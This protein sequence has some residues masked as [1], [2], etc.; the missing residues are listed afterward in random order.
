MPDG[1]SWEDAKRRFGGGEVAPA[2]KAAPL[3]WEDA[4]AKFGGGMAVAE[5]PPDFET[6]LKHAPEAPVDPD[7]PMRLSRPLDQQLGD[8]PVASRPATAAAWAEQ[9][10]VARSPLAGDPE[11]DQRSGDV[12][13]EPEG[14]VV[15]RLDREDAERQRAAAGDRADV[16]AWNSYARKKFGV[17]A[18]AFVT[19]DP[20][21]AR[22]RAA[23]NAADEDQEYQRDKWRIMV[24]EV[25]RGVARGASM[26][27]ADPLFNDQTAGNIKDYE[28]KA[29]RR[30]S[31]A[32]FVEQAAYAGTE[33]AASLPTFGGLGRVATAAHVPKALHMPAVMGTYG[34]VS[35]ESGHRLEG[36][37]K[38]I[39]FG[40]L[41]P[42]VS[43]RLLQALSKLTPEAAEAVMARVNN[44]ISQAGGFTAAGQ[45]I[46]PGEANAGIDAL[47]GAG[48]GLAGARTVFSP[49]LRDVASPET[50]ANRRATAEAALRLGRDPIADVNADKLGRTDP[51]VE[52]TRVQAPPVVTRREEDEAPARPQEAPVPTEAP[53]VPEADPARPGG[54]VEPTEAPR[55]EAAPAL[56]AQKPETRSADRIESEGK[57]KSLVEYVR[58]MGGIRADGYL[59]GEVERL[60]VK[61]SATSGLVARAKGRGLG[62]EEM[63]QSL[64][65]SGYPVEDMTPPQLLDAIE[66]EATKR[67]APTLSPETSDLH[68]LAEAD[69]RRRAESD[70]RQLQDQ[71]AP[72]PEAHYAEPGPTSMKRAVVDAE[73]AERG[74]EPVKGSEPQTREGWMEYGRKAV[75]AD[76]R[77]PDILIEKFE[78]DPSL[79]MKPHERAIL[80]V[81]QVDIRRSRALADAEGVDAAK[82]GDLGAL[83]DATARARVESDAL[84]RLD[85][86]SKRSGE[87]WS[88]SGSAAQMEVK[89]DYSL[90][91]NEMKVRR[92][93]AYRE[94]SERESA[95]VRAL[96]DRASKAEA[97]R[98][99]Y[100]GR[101]AEV[102]TWR[103]EHSSRKAPPRASPEYG[104]KNKIVTREAYEESG[105]AIKEILGRMGSGLDKLAIVP[106]LTKRAIFH[107]EA[108]G[109]GFASWA[110]QMRADFGDKVEPYLKDAWDAAQADFAP[111]RIAALEKS[112]ERSIAEYNRRIASGD[113]FPA[114]K[115]D[116]PS[117]PKLDA[118]RA[119]RDEL[120]KD[121]ASLREAARPRSGASAIAEK[122]RETRLQKTLDELE[123]RVR[124]NDVSTKPAKAKLPPTKKAIEL[125][126]KVDL[127]HR[128]VDEMVFRHHLAN[129]S[130]A[131]KAADTVLQ[132]AQTARAVMTSFDVSAPLRQGLFYAGAHP[133]AAARALGP[134]LQAMRSPEGMARIE[135]EMRMDADFHAAKRSGV[136]FSESG[137]AS[138]I[139]KMEEAYMSR[140]AEKIPLVAGSQRAYTTFL[141]RA[142][143]DYFKTL[144]AGFKSGREA[145]PKE[146]KA[147]ASFVNA[148]TGRGGPIGEAPWIAG[149]NHYLFSP[150]LL[151][152]RIQLLTGHG[153]IYGGGSLRT[154]MIIAKEYARFLGSTAA[155]FGMAFAAGATVEE[156][157][158]S[159]DF[160]KLRWGNARL[161]PL[162]G[163]AQVV[164]LVSRVATGESKPTG[165]GVKFDWS[166]ARF[167]RERG[168]GVYPI[169]GA[170]AKPG[171]MT[172]VLTRFLR[173]KL[174]P[175]PGAIWSSAAGEDV[176]G[177]KTTAARE[178]SGL[179]I[180]MSFGGKDLFSTADKKTVTPTFVTG[181]DVFQAMKQ[182]GVPAGAAMWVLSLFGMGLQ[183]H[184]EKKKNKPNPK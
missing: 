27:L 75:E 8:V 57:G 128:A 61:G 31:E 9:L 25:A 43:H 147:I 142:R 29:N 39:A 28:A 95:E 126:A 125:Q 163:M 118:L 90:A 148:A 76:S 182:Q 6:F 158:R 84:A 153:V 35:A 46:N 50:L 80:L 146:M 5:A 160:G 20:A 177:N 40:F 86:I 2:E 38:G 113:A 145:T 155:L 59:A 64:K 102:E 73:R 18:Q 181:S 127:A 117:G 143:L 110:A 11:R 168:A 37:G 71:P 45:L 26:G 144:T 92:E 74:L 161:D 77:A 96:S 156:D 103:A 172:Q 49:R 136:F 170:G 183:V 174:A 100:A 79:S 32:G 149:M 105:R 72:T 67:Q 121:L 1:L 82:R 159:S 152:S 108:A 15:R 7:A 179:V 134:M 173:S 112:A 55:A 19:N 130:A 54:A 62:P 21:K 33:I 56:E 133:R 166:K 109:R 16:E 150:R 138:S 162:G 157:P 137:G 115:G 60:A 68:A 106:H 91:T 65:E 167:D 17:M 44:V 122:A 53:R 154:R 169:R 131:Q 3:S 99:A 94:L 180:P 85:V 89:D 52:P 58:K 111:R 63:L 66:M 34:A 178:A 22:E 135:A 93:N 104:K 88:R 141:N 24:M 101:L 36:A 97:E 51:F 175:I 87:A 123:R 151:A 107:I 116:A 132:T 129:R 171:G 184:D 41:A 70:A 13:L 114:K 23:E 30:R 10:G 83:A 98:D 140:W 4:K 48:F 176:I 124:E 119:E 12:T 47:I 165:S 120:R 81:R 14:D 69:F 139:S 42:A 164:T 78:K